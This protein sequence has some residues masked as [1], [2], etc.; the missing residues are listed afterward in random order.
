[1]CASLRYYLFADVGLNLKRLSRRMV[2]V[3][4]HDHAMPEY[5]G[6]NAKARIRYNSK[7]ERQADQKSQDGGMV[8]DKA[9]RIN[10][11]Q[12]IDRAVVAFAGR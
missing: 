6:T 12:K 8:F 11:P 5:T 3:L 4:I 2:D 1:M 7:R 10:G 9:G